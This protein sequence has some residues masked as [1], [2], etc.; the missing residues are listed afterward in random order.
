MYWR[1]M[2]KE[3]SSGGELFIVDNSISGWAGIR[4]LREL[5]DQT[6]FFDYGRL[7]IQGGSLVG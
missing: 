6:L 4:Y 2:N 5:Q 1:T 3:I 7:E